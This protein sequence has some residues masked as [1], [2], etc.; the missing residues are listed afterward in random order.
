MYLS[1]YNHTLHFGEGNISYYFSA[2][3]F[4]YIRMWVELL[5]LLIEEFR[6]QIRRYRVVRPWVG[7][8]TQILRVCTSRYPRQFNKFYP[9]HERKEVTL[10]SFWAKAEV[11]VVSIINLQ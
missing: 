1:K 6:F 9:F 7:S 5:Y 3:T 8:G 2:V 10:L 4:V 11:H